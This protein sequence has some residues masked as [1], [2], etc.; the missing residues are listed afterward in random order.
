VNATLPDDVRGWLTPRE[1]SILAREAAGRVALEVGAFCGKAT[2]LLAQVCPWVVSVDW[3]RGDANIGDQDSLAEFVAN[4]RKHRVEGRVVPAIGRVED[5]GQFLRDGFASFVYV[6]AE[7]YERGARASIECVRH[8][9]APGCVWAFHDYGL[10]DVQ[11]V[12]KECATLYGWALREES[13]EH[14]LCIARS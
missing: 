9:A 14:G 6:D 3:H 10:W 13:T 1:A 7:H 4:L 11:K 8:C 5:V 12:V 2:I